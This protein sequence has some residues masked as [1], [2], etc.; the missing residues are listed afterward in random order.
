MSQHTEA[1]SRVRFS[2]RSAFDNPP[3]QRHISERERHKADCRRRI[4]EFKE[5][6]ELA[7]QLAELN[8]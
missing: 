8:L 5:G 7:R 4:E 6:R 2:I 3:E 1:L